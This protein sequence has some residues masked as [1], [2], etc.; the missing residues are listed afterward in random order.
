M[1][2]ARESHLR[3]TIARLASL[4]EATG[5]REQLRDQG[6]FTG[7]VMVRLAARMDVLAA[8]EGRR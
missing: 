2:E 1:D 3:Q 7:E 5:F 6:E 4:A 8:R